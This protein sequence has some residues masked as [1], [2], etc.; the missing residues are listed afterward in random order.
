MLAH[1]GYG[2]LVGLQQAV[3]DRV[4]VPLDIGE[5]RA[6]L[7]GNVGGQIAAL[8]FRGLQ[9]L[10]HCIE[11]IAQVAYLRRARGRDTLAEVALTKPLGSAAKGPNR[12][13]NPA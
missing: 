8:L 1:G 2:C 6:Q 10:G 3:V 12:R 4:Q 5:G 9:V 11:G 13:Q 7:V